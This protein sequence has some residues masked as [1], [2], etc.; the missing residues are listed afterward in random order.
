MAENVKLVAMRIRTL[1]E[2]SGESAESVAK[3]LNLP[4]DE[5]ARYESGN[6]DIPVSFMYEIAS[7]F[8]VE[9]TALLTGG[10]PHMNSYS[11]VRSGSG[12]AV[13]RSSEYRYRDLAYNFIHKKMEV[14]EVSVDPKEGGKISHMNS[15]PGQEYNYCLEGSLKVVIGSNEV[16]LNPGDSLFFDSGKK[17]A[18][19]SMNNK[20]A[21][22]LAVIS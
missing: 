5:Y 15:H 19:A 10:E 20:P 3:K 8:K 22:F 21:R 7:L 9:L 12:P 17:H 18:M 6:T 11:I 2:I 13:E 4:A 1:R 14:F 16:I